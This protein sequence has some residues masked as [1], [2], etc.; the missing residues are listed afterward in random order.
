MRAFLVR[1][2]LMSLVTLVAVSMI[3][4]M[5]ARIQGDPRAVMLSDYTTNEQY[6]AWGREMGLDKPIAIQYVVYMG[7]VIRGDLG[8]SL[9]QHGTSVGTLLWRRIPNTVQLSIAAFIFSLIIGIPLGV[10]AAIAR[11]SVWDS[12]ARAFAIFGHSAPSFWVGLIFIVLFAVELGWFPTSRNDD[13]LKSLVLPSLALGWG[14]AGGILRLMRSAMLEV[15]DSEYV[16]LAKAKGMSS[17]QVIWKHAFR[18][19]LIAPLTAAGLLFAGLITGTVVTESVFAWP[20]LGLLA[21]QAVNKSDYPVLQ[22]V[23]LLVTVIYVVTA[24]AVDLLYAYIDP[25]IKYT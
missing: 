20:G 15:L 21:I 11:A 22:G 1:R 23:I 6:E 5:L 12:S 14:A 10:L 19:A 3:V 13:G 8:D 9:L 25:R 16:K 18:N 24:L 4:F 7:K 2:A 17:A